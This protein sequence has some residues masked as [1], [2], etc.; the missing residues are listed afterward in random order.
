MP[1][2]MEHEPLDER[3]RRAV[4]QLRGDVATRPLPELRLRPRRRWLAPAL[5]L[6]TVTVVVAGLVAIGTNRNDAS[7]RRPT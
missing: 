3:A 2:V 5:A 7:G 4:T 1:E 6:S